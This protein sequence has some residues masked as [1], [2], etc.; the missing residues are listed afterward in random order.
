MN[1]RYSG[2]EGADTATLPD[3]YSCTLLLIMDVVYS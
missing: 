2:A 1:M 3:G